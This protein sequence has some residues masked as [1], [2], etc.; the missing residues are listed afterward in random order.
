MADSKHTQAQDASGHATAGSAHPPIDSTLLTVTN[1][2]E[3]DY[4]RRGVFP[5][6]RRCNAMNPHAGSC[7]HF[8]PEAEALDVLADAKGL[9]PHVAG[10]MRN[11][12]GAHIRG[13]E[14]AI[15]NAA[16]RV[17]L[18]AATE[19]ICVSDSTIR[20]R[21]VGTKANLQARLG[22]VLSGPWPK[23]PGGKRWVHTCDSRGYKAALTPFSSTWPGLFEVA[24]TVPAPKREAATDSK[25]A[26]RATQSLRN[27]PTC[28]AEFLRELLDSSRVMVRI[29][30][31]SAEKGSK[32]HGYSIDS[33]SVADIYLGFDAVADA[34][35]GATTKFDAERHREIAQAHR[36]V[37][38][39][40]DGGFQSKFADLTRARPDL[41]SGDAR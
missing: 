13:I 9:L 30:V 11:A 15:A 21:W 19:A 32:S 17:R 34:I 24:I 16:E 7:V 28:A 20:P 6:L 29:C 40:A 35:M 1:T 41:L 5:R 26:E 10:P 39:A 36:A 4:A 37:V 31:E 23:E 2:V 14:S 27:M 3:A 8:T 33:D 25:E 12:Y 22:I 18:F 38:A